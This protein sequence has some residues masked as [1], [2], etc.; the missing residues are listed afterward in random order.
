MRNLWGEEI[1][2]ETKIC[3]DCK[4]EKPI[5]QFSVNRKFYREDLPEKHYAIRRPACDSCRN[6][7]LKI[8]KEKKFWHRPINL[9]CPI[10]H[11]EVLGS[12]ARLD[13]NHHTGKIRGWICDNCNTA[14]GKLKESSEVIQRAMEW[15]K[16]DTI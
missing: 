13:H 14:I 10:C 16:N 7:K 11:D 12:Y 3:R 6:K 1:L 5:E 4:E 8:G 9:T 2:V 15:I